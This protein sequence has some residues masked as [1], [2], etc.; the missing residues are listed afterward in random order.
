MRRGSGMIAVRL[1]PWARA[2]AGVARR[3]SEMLAE[4]A[5]IWGAHRG[6]EPISASFVAAASWTAPVLWRF[7]HAGSPIESARGLA[8]SKTLRGFGRF[9]ASARMRKCNS[10]VAPKFPLF[11]RPVLA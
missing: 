2:Y 10:L 11:N 8:Q 3:Q 7:W 9:M 6:P 4:S 5:A 1:R